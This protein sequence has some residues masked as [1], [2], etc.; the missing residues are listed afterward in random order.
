[1]RDASDL[2]ALLGEIESLIK[3]ALEANVE[4]RTEAKRVQLAALAETERVQVAHESA[5]ANLEAALETRDL[6]GQAKGVI[7]ATMGCPSD[8]AFALIAQQSQHEN[9]KVIDIATDIVKRA[10]RKRPT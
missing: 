2:T 8:E 1:M 10:N 3:D 6:I 7:M 4:S 5:V 9:R